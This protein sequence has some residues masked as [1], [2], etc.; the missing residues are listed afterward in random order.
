MRDNAL[1]AVGGPQLHERRT[2]VEAE[3]WN[4]FVTAENLF[5]EDGAVSGFAA[6]IPSGG[7]PIRPWP[8]TIGI[9]LNVR[10]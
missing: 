9:E 6:F 7:E 10:I 4:F 8:R 3:K 1:T 2:G 5:D